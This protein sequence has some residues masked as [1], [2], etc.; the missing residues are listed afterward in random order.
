MREE[1]K[2]KNE[3]PLEKGILYEL[4]PLSWPLSFQGYEPRQQGDFRNLEAVFWDFKGLPHYF[5]KCK[6]AAIA[7]P[8]T[9]EKLWEYAN[10]A[11][12]LFQWLSIQERRIAQSRPKL[13]EKILGQK[14]DGPIGLT[15]IQKR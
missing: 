4:P 6:I 1:F 5:N 13:T 15:S 7:T 11:M 9:S 8:T 2:D 3:N 12:S 10:S 14:D